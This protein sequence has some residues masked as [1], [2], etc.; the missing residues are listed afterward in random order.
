MLPFSSLTVIKVVD[1]SYFEKK[2]CVK[3]LSDT[4]NDTVER[5]F[6]NSDQERAF[7]IVS[8][9]AISM[10][11]EQLQMYMEGMGGTGKSQVIKALSS[12]FETRHEAH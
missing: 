4:I 1:K 2:F 6:L 9:H 5:F 10:N 3:R 12:F 7:Q 11:V 8:N